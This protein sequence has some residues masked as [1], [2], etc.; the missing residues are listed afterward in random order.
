MKVR[1]VDGFVVIDMFNIP[2]TAKTQVNIEVE[3]DMTTTDLKL[4]YNNMI[5]F[6]ADMVWKSNIIL[7]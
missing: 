3:N 2:D 5:D 7:R 6:V 4:N 1:N